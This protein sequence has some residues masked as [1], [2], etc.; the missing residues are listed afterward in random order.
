M[1]IST[2]AALIGSAAL[3]LGG[4]I[5]SGN[6]AKKATKQAADTS[7]QTAAMNNALA[8]SV[9][10]STEGFVRPYWARGNAAGDQINAMLGLSNNAATLP[11]SA[12]GAYQGATMPPAQNALSGYP[13]A[14]PASWQPSYAGEL[15]YTQEPA[16]RASLQNPAPLDYD[17]GNIPGAYGAPAASYLPQV[18]PHPY[19]PITQETWFDSSGNPI[20]TNHHL[21]LPSQV[22]SGE[23]PNPYAP[24]PPP[25]SAPNPNDPF[26]RYIEGSDY[27]FQFGQGSNA[28]NSGYA[29][30]GA[31]Q[32]GAAQKALEKYRQNLQAGYRGEYMNLLGQQQAVG[33]SGASALAGVGQNYA[34]LVTSNNS[35]AGSDAANAALMRGSA[36]AN[37]FN[38][39]GSGLGNLLGSS[40]MMWGGGGRNMVGPNI[41]GM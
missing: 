4:S 33:L 23:V 39:I 7:M 17:E 38:N 9:R 31:L 21:P 41:V 2:G 35:Q 28:V 18:S 19:G 1:A 25:S 34:G 30:N 15:H 6:S 36:N 14:P 40:Y 24:A 3:G 26:R 5:L 20:P 16:Y 13:T 11:A 10:A 8:A 37:M 12:L 29:A 27:A 32:S 22:M